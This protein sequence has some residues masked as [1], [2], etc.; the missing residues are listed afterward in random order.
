M[1][2]TARSVNLRLALL[3][4]IAMQPTSC[5]PRP[6]GSN[7]DPGGSAG[8]PGGVSGDLASLCDEY[9][10]GYLRAHPAFAT[11]I[12]DRRYDARLEEVTPEA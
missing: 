3:L 1:A 12:G 10:Q 8:A 4:V 2:P 6:S 11:S 7:A 9:W 5:G